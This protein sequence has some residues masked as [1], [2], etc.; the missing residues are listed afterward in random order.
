LSLY[1][2]VVSSTAELIAKWQ[3]VGFFHGVM[4]TDNFSLLSI[5]IDYG[6]FR[7]M[8]DYDPQMIPNTSDDDGLYRYINQ[9]HVAKFNLGKL[10]EALGPLLSSFQQTQMSMILEGFSDIYTRKHRTLFRQKLG[11]CDIH[12]QDKLDHVIYSL[13]NIMEETQSDFTMTFRQLAE[14]SLEDLKKSKI[15]EKFWAV[16]SLMTYY[17]VKEWLKTYTKM[18]E[19]CYALILE[20]QRQENMRKINPRYVLRNWIAQQAISACE[21]NDFSVVRKVHEILKNPF[22]EQEDAE[23][24]GYAD[25]PPDWGKDL[26]VSCSS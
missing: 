5:T 13:L 7:F 20:K 21:E 23:L 22:T 17:N 18:V 6:P 14:L 11:I 10:K 8:D 26:K 12:P 24:S 19:D 3:S 16:K 15:P 25:P 4:N 9:P 2:E 1:S